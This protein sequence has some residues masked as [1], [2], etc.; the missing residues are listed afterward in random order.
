M[1]LFLCV[2]AFQCMAALTLAAVLWLSIRIE[3]E[4]KIKSVD[5]MRISRQK[6]FKFKFFSNYFATYFW[7][8]KTF[9][10]RWKIFH[11]PMSLSGL[12]LTLNRLEISTIFKVGQ[13]LSLQ[14]LNSLSLPGCAFKCSRIFFMAKFMT[15]QSINWSWLRLT[16]SSSRWLSLPFKAQASAPSNKT[17]QMAHPNKKN[18]VVQTNLFALCDVVNT[19]DDAT[20]KAQ[21]KRERCSQAEEEKAKGYV[22]MLRQHLIISISILMLERCN[23]HKVQLTLFLLHSSWA[24]FSTA[25]VKGTLR[26]GGNLN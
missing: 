24:L 9:Y 13:T 16:F 5:L 7:F 3:N 19:E 21:R 26:V 20:A 2:A 1:D 4:L 22:N 12:N 11:F 25:A 15:L 23:L 18:D 10:C 6:C 17:W 14:K 8:L